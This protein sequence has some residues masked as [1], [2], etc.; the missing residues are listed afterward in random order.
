M[1]RD[2]HDATVAIHGAAL[3]EDFSPWDVTFVPR[4]VGAA[5][6]VVSTEKR[7]GKIGRVCVLR[8]HRRRHRR[9][10][11]ARVWMR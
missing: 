7:R 3:Y 8:D 5:R 11:C 10:A 9:R 6:V 2:A 4:P 1:E